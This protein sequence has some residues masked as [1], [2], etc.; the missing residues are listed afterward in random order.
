MNAIEL[1]P[2]IRDVPD[3]PQ[4]GIVFRD[5]TP[6][7]ASPAAF[8]AAVTL[9]AEALHRHRTEQILAIDSRGF[10]FGAALALQT[11]LP[12][13]LVRKAG[14]LPR[15][16]VG[17]DYQLEYGSDRL[18]AHHEALAR[19][20]RYAVVDDVIATGGTAGAV[21]ELVSR[22]GGIV[23]CCAF[24]LELGFLGGRARLAGI[25]VESLIRYD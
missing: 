19:D 3:F 15:A 12:L 22:E 24:L 16:T 10:I 5:I 11:S 7:L 13:H 17:I 2:F 4:T 25:T 6:L 23:A 21:V 18:E 1:Q 8:A 9:L 14:K 20:V